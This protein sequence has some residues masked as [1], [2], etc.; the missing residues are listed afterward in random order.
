MST[1]SGLDQDAIDRLAGA[2]SA[3]IDQK[4]L[5]NQV[6]SYAHDDEVREI[7]QKTFIETVHGRKC[8]AILAELTHDTDPVNTTMREMYLS[9]FMKLIY[10]M[11]G[12]RE[13]RAATE[14]WLE[15]MAPGILLAERHRRAAEESQ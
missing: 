10:L 3:E 13:N 4:V 11:C 14:A 8:L 15:V 1:P 5:N 2:Y 6:L 7:F 9:N 12:I